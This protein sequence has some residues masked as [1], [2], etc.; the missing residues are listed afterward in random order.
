LESL[1]PSLGL[2]SDRTAPLHGKWS[3][4]VTIVTVTCRGAGPIPGLSVGAS[5][6]IGGSAWIFGEGWDVGCPGGH[7]VP[8]A[9]GF[10]AR[11]SLWSD[12]GQGH[13]CGRDD[14]R[15]REVV[16]LV[17]R[18]PLLERF[19]LTAGGPELPGEA[20]LLRHGRAVNGGSLGCLG[21]HFVP[22]AA[23]FPARARFCP[24]SG[25]KGV[26]HDFPVARAQKC[27]VP[28]PFQC[29]YRAD[30]LPRATR[31]DRPLPHRPEPRHR[32]D[33]PA[34]PS[35]PARSASGLAGMGRPRVIRLDAAVGCWPARHPASRGI[36]P[37]RAKSSRPSM[38]NQT[39]L[40]PP[41]R[42]GW[43]GS[44]G[45]RTRKGNRPRPAQSPVARSPAPAECPGSP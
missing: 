25:Q 30:R 15:G 13:K 14:F 42:A 12:M 23:G 19:G 45:S 17:G 32:Q 33:G 22:R 39:L 44:G 7:F 20:G 38:P 34:W 21:G 16:V 8:R 10:P 27:P 36:Q 1:S 31:G 26:R 40:S 6:P 4:I 18:P 2:G 3:R 35:Q 11:S 41:A 43:K 29:P 9:V 37:P 28:P 5:L 24:D